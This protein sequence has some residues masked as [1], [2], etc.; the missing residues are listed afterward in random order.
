MEP[1]LV[2]EM[3]VGVYPDELRSRGEDHHRAVLTEA[4]VRFILESRKGVSALARM[5]GCSN[6]A[7]QAVKQRR[8]WKH[9]SGK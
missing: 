1:S 4:Q 3:P 8:S 2:N 9:V 6:G 7:V 5:F